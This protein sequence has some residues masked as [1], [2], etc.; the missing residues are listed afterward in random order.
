MDSI[1]GL[2]YIDDCFYNYEDVKEK[3]KHINGAFTDDDSPYYILI[4]TENAYKSVQDMFKELLKNPDDFTEQYL[5]EMD[6]YIHEYLWNNTSIGDS[7]IFGNYM[8]FEEEEI[9]KT[10]RIYEKILD[11]YK[12]NNSLNTFKWWSELNNAIL[13]FVKQK[14]AEEIIKQYELL[15]NYGID[16]TILKNAI[17]I[18]L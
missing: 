1:L 3:V 17:N 14:V 18:N 5:W 16:C 7:G 13:T 8:P 6:S 15:E 12:T 2:V 9:G 11:T 10:W 4:T